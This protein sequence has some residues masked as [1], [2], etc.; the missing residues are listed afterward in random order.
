MSRH[1]TQ[2]D[3]NKSS[4]EGLY[5]RWSRRKKSAREPGDDIGEE[6]GSAMVEESEQAIDAEAAEE[7]VKT[8]ADMPPIDSIDENTNIQDFFSPG[9][10]ETL[11]K[12]A[13]RKLFHLPIFNIVDGLDDYDDDFL[14]DL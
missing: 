14:T 12:A 11:R 7:P 1:P 8:D 5:S 3:P 2:D 6:E 13:L 9:V 4:D 10:S